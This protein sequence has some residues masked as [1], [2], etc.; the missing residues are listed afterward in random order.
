VTTL[1]ITEAMSVPGCCWLEVVGTADG[2]SIGALL[3][4][5]TVAGAEFVWLGATPELV[6]ATEI[7]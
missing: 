4:A 7:G 5:V 1:L 6:A 3:V 2:A